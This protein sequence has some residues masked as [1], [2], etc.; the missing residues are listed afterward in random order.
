[1]HGI[2]DA[3]AHFSAGRWSDD[4]FSPRWAFLKSR[5]T[6]GIGPLTLVQ[7]ADG[8][9]QILFCGA[10]GDQ[11]LPAAS[12]RTLIDGAPGNNIMPGTIQ[13]NTN[14]GG[15]SVTPSMLIT[16]KGEVRPLLSLTDAVVT[17][18]DSATVVLDASQGNQFKLVAAGDRT[19]AA[20]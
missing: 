10:D 1:V 16:T 4:S 11:F 8:I 13:F 19:I 5:S 20:P 6:T 2:S 14:R 18:T 7:D 17:L 9:G 15:T 12:I 3:T